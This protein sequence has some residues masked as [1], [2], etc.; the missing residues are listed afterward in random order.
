MKASKTV[1][2]CS[3]C[4]HQ[5]A[6]WLGKCPQCGA[7]N[8]FVE[9]TYQPPAKASS[10]S[11]SPT[12]PRIER[13]H[14]V[15]FGDFTLPE[16]LRHSTGLGE[17]D[18]VLGGGLVE[19]SVILLAGE[20]GIGKSTLLMQL[21]GQIGDSCKVLY[22]SGEE[23]KGQLK[24]RA[25]RLGVSA[26]FL[27][28]LTETSIEAILSEYDK[29]KPDLMIVDSIQTMFTEA[30]SSMSGSVTQVRECS[31]LL[32]ERAKT[33]GASVVIVGHVNKEGGI[34]GP[35][36]LEHMV[37][38]V[39]Y[40]EG[41][42][43]QPH[44]IVRAIK[45]RFGSTNEIGV[46]EMGEEGL[47][48]VA[49]PSAMLLEGR[50]LGVSGSCAVCIMEGTRPLIAEIQALVTPTV[51]PSPRRTG[52]GIDYNR[53]CLL[54]AVLEKRL[55]LKF[56]SHDVYLNVIGG[57]RLD[58]PAIDAACCLAMISSLR[59]IPVPDDI[60]AFGE[61]GLSGEFRTVASVEQRVNEAFRL[62]FTRI[63]LPKKAAA[64]L[65]SNPKHA[66][67]FRESGVELIP[68]SGIYDALRLLGNRDQ[69][70]AASD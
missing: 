49:N 20:P 66:D 57:L 4:D 26:E 12:S 23:S 60:I 24:M 58:E 64:Q 7:W 18:R 61:L 37:D 2:V 33:D 29:I 15:K 46:F 11:N 54:L 3:E 13:D 17:L 40:F 36:V 69:K 16:Y 55:G 14:A 30:A 32:I 65:L 48:E 35:K 63:A 43:R 9:E 25:D 45:N 59:D 39:L 53:M 10:K 68:L 34:A 42:R 51:F 67:A 6:K 8:S 41:D 56:S 19:G 44:R 50:P 62:G 27:Y 47:S 31:S 52:N 22:V 28:V 38:A 1:Y 5:S 21:C 70:E